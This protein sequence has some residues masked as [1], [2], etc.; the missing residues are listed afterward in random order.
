MSSWPRS[1]APGAASGRRAASA[2]FSSPDSSGTRWKNWKTNPTRRARSRARSRSERPS[3]RSPASSIVPASALSR[4]PSRCRS[5]DFP[6]PDRPTTATSSPPDTSRAAPSSTR[7]AARPCPKVLTR[8][9]ARTI[10]DVT[11]EHGTSQGVTWGEE[12]SAGA[13]KD[14]HAPLMPPARTTKKAPKRASKPAPRRR[15]RRSSAASLRLP[16]LDQRQLDLVGLGLVAIAVFLVFPLWLGLGGGRRGRGRHGRPAPRRRRGRLRRAGRRWPRSARSS[17]CDRC[18]RPSARCAP[19]RCASSAPSPSRSPPARSASEP[20]ACARATGTAPGWRSTAASSARPCSTRSTK[21]VGSVGAH[22]LAVFL[23]VAGVHPADRRLGRRGHPATHSGVTRHHARRCA[24][25]VPAAHA[26]SRARRAAR[27][28]RT[29][30]CIVTATRC[31]RRRSTPASATPTSSASPTRRP[32][33]SRSS[34]S[35]SPSTNRSRRSPRRIEPEPDAA[36]TTSPSPT[37]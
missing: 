33:P 9:C 18:C 26:P 10:G 3:T 14:E 37:A 20:T 35:P 15:A 29:R 19:A 34:R 32:T 7:R 6:E 5:V 8:P 17:S 21:A 31:A 22:I 28:P 1:S 16:V 25:P 2:T 36:R 30:R 13:S 11:R 23:F 27:S 24:P 4:P 12:A